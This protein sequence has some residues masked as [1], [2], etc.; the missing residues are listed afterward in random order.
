MNQNEILPG[1]KTKETNNTSM[2]LF[3]SK[4]DRFQDE[5]SLDTKK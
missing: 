3:D 5:I 4:T 1:K 2:V